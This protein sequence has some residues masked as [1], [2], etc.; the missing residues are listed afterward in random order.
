MFMI[1]PFIGLAVAVY[2]VFVFAGG[3]ILGADFTSMWAFLG[4]PLV[5]IDLPSGDGWLL[6]VGDVFVVGG[7]L[8]LALE[9]VKSTSTTGFSIGNH[10]LSMLVFVVAVVL[11]LVVQGF[12]TT[13]FFLLT[14]MAFVD[15]LVGMIVSIVTARRDFGVDQGVFGNG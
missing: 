11:F 8:A 13:T 2:A 7:L 6:T 3:A 4:Q 9:S 5:T 12:G 15:G 1:F 10:G 14:A